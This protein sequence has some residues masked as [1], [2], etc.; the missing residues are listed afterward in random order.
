MGRVLDNMLKRRGRKWGDV[1]T[2]SKLGELLQK[3]GVED[4][5]EID[6]I[7]SLPRRKWEEN[8]DLDD[9]GL[10][11]TD[12]FRTSNGEQEVWPIQTAA[13]ADVHDYDGL[14]GPIGVGEGKT[15]LTRLMPLV[16]EADRPV[17][18]IPGKLRQKTIDEFAELDAH[19]IAHPNLILITYEKI[20]RRKSKDLLNK[21]NPDLI[22]ADEAHKLKNLDAGCT[23]RVARWMN[24]HFNETIFVALSGTIT[25]RNLMDYWHLALW[26]L[27]PDVAP[28]PNDPREA[29]CWSLALGTKVPLER[30]PAVGALKRFIVSRKNKKKAK[31]TL[32]SRNEVRA[33]YGTR[34][35]ETPGVVASFGDQVGASIVIEFWDPVLS[36]DAQAVALN[37]S[38]E[39][40]GPEGE[41]ILNGAEIWRHLREAVCGYYSIWDPEP[42]NE[43]LIPRRRFGKFVREAL[44]DFPE[45]YDTPDQVAQACEEELLDSGG[46][47]E[48]WKTVE[49]TFKPNTVEHWIDTE[50][51][52]KL[53]K[54][55]PPKSLVWVDRHAVGRKLAEL[56]GWPFHHAG[57]RD[58]NGRYIED[59]QGEQTA[60]LSVMANLE[61]RNLQKWSSNVVVSPL[62]DGGVLEQQIGRTHRRGQEADEVN[63]LFMLGHE[64]LRRGMDQA[65]RDAKY[66]QNTTGVR[67]KLG[68]ADV[69][70]TYEGEGQDAS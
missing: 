22:V 12:V 18:L 58:D 27:G 14:L 45:K 34:L 42:P 7:L 35:R 29:A 19:W 55:T 4:S 31:K 51:L 13:L 33:A 1:R 21:I 26:A 61:G 65:F 11:L 59:L 30:Q 47:Y 41:P 3:R 60:I 52:E 17:L 5:S 2:S 39:Y 63:V 23:K 67:S 50:V 62:P 20:A 56:T 8:P 28:V 37:V 48:H 70:N 6:R 38:R 44:K 24:K 54:R 36:L 57:G 46:L 9:L 15:L 64:V 53:I 68:L 16:L 25:K 10:Y 66:I 40:V 32:P 49:K 43:W 69:V